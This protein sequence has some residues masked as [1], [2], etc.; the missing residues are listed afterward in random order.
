MK[1][2]QSYIILRDDEKVFQNVLSE[3]SKVNLQKKIE[4][5]LKELALKF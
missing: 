4:N 1:E 5:F 3:K 2:K